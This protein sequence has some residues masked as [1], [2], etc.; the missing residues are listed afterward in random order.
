LKDSSMEN[1]TSFDPRWPLQ[2]APTIA[3]H[4]PPDKA[5]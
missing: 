5:G 3:S 2:I 4:I 1:G